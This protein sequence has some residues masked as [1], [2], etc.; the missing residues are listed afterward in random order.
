M[1]TTRI[2]PRKALSCNL[3]KDC[4][5]IWQTE[6]I[7]FDVTLWVDVGGTEV[8]EMSRYCKTLNEAEKVAKGW[9]K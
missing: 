4:D 8:P 3:G 7:G 2:Y 9:A 1:K 5:S 6:T